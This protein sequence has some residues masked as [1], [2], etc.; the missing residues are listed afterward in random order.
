MSGFFRSSQND[1]F[2]QSCN[3]RSLWQTENLFVAQ[4]E[5][6]LL[7][8]LPIAP[9]GKVLEVGCGTGSN[10]HNVRALGRTFS[11]TGVDINEAELALAHH[12]FPNDY[13]ILGD[14]ATVPFVDRTFDVVFCRDLLHH[15]SLAQQKL[16]IAEMARVTRA[17]GEVVIIESN[18]RN[19]IIR[20]FGTLVRAE[21]G[22]LFS[23][24]ERMI[25]L[26]QQISNLESVRPTPIFAEPCNMF[27]VALHYRT[28]LPGLA[29]W[30]MVRWILQI[31]N[32]LM[33]RVLTPDRW[34]Y[35]ILR[36]RKRY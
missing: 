6:E 7:S 30:R 24:P 15:V 20:A 12:C 10:V 8:H 31:V 17:D 3:K 1:Y 22:V 9:G 2:A 36:A 34:S 26:V 27:R 18:A 21:R 4:M 19:I 16:V 32:R 33:A 35:M 5:R 25:R 29:A 14:A 23:T 11:F 28:G 13:F